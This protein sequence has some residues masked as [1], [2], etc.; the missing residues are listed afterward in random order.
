MEGNSGANKPVIKLFN[1]SSLCFPSCSCP[2]LPQMINTCVREMCALEKVCVYVEAFGP[3]IGVG[4]YRLKL[5]PDEVTMKW[6][7]WGK[8]CILP[9]EFQCWCF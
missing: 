2:F 7:K 6:W 5:H 1:T 3:E 9:S 8:K 4:V